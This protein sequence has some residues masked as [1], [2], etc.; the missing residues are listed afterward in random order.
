[1]KRRKKRRKERKDLGG[2]ELADRH[3]KVNFFHMKRNKFHAFEN[4]NTLF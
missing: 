4:D 1:M 2:S 3:R